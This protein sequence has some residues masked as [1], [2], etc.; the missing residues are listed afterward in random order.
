MCTPLHVHFH[1]FKQS[2]KIFHILS[3]GSWTWFLCALCLSWSNW[4]KHLFFPPFFLLKDQTKESPARSQDTAYSK[5]TS[6]NVLT[7]CNNNKIFIY[8]LDKSKVYRAVRWPSE[9]S[10]VQLLLLVVDTSNEPLC[11]LLDFNHNFS[12]RR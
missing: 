6:F 1:I 2:G 3:T 10:K 5:S 7:T 8:C 12:F 9:W 11:S 4:L